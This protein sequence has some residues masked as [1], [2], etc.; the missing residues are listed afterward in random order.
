LERVNF[1]IY[2]LNI[3]ENFATTKKIY[4][5]TKKRVFR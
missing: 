1:I 2:R 3:A 5:R 4:R